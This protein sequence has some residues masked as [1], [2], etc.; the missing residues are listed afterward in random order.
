MADSKADRKHPCSLGHEFSIG[1]NKY[2]KMIYKRGKYYSSGMLRLV[3]LKGRELRVGFSAS[4][5]VGNAVTRNRL[6]RWMR[7]DFRMVRSRLRNGK[8]IFIAKV[9]AEKLTHDELKRDLIASLELA[10]L[11]VV[12]EVR[13]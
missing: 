9:G 13:Q 1:R 10:G 5:K 11:F 2:F 7:E 12:D 3:F 6:R 8:Y 4:G